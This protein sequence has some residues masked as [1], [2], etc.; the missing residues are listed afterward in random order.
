MN[1]RGF[2]GPPGLSA[3]KQA[4]YH[5]V[6]KKMYSTGEWESVRARNG[7]AN[8]YKPGPDFVS[9]LEDQ[10]KQI[11]ALMKELGFL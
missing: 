2:F 11:G 3:E 7:W 9:F 1:W 5:A 4:A 6:L 10:E 8:I